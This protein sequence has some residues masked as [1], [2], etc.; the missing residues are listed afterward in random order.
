MVFKQVPVYEQQEVQ[1]GWIDT[2]VQVPIYGTE[3]YIRT[4]RTETVGGKPRRIVLDGQII[5]V[6]SASTTRQVPVYGTRQVVVGYRTETR[7]EPNMVMQE[8]QV[9]SEWRW[10]LEE[11]P[12]FDEP[13]IAIA[14]RL[15]TPSPETDTPAATATQSPPNMND[16][17]PIVPE[18][19]PTAPMVPTAST[20]LSE[21]TPT[22]TPHT[23]LDGN[24]QLYDVAAFLTPMPD[25]TGT[26][27]RPP[28]SVLLHEKHLR[29]L[30]Q[31]YLRQ[32]PL[33]YIRENVYWAN[34]I[35]YRAAVLN[36]QDNPLT[37]EIWNSNETYPGEIRPATILTSMDPISKEFVASLFLDP[38]HITNYEP[39]FFVEL[40][41]VNSRIYE[42]IVSK[43]IT[44]EGV[45]LYTWEDIFLRQIYRLLLPSSVW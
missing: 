34:D 37:L 18:R 25:P 27:T 16:D 15:E 30:Q 19:Y 10:V 12:E 23:S 8:V 44:P 14:E 11:I 38:S 7:R 24:V 35:D 33:E 1:D 42:R 43:Y 4:Y 36:G 3:R 22:E 17:E 40:I 41:R 28:D 5:T 29:T 26:P 13:Q 21:A 20:E 2:E 9:G 32:E 31:I 6:Y 39:I 45:D